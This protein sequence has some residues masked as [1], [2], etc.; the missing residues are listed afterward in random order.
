MQLIGEYL[1]KLKEIR[2]K[3]LDRMGEIMIGGLEGQQKDRDE[4]LEKAKEKELADNERALRE[5]LMDVETYNEKEIKINDKYR[6]YEMENEVKDNLDK[7]YL[8]QIL[9]IKKKEMMRRYLLAKKLMALAEIGLNTTVAIMS[10]L[11][12]PPPEGEVFALL[13]AQAGITQLIAAALTPIPALAKGTKKSKAGLHKVGEKGEELVMLPQH[14]KVLP[15][16]KTKLHSEVIDAMFDNRLEEYILKR[17][18]MPAVK[19]SRGN[20][21]DDYRLWKAVK[22]NK[23][24]SIDNISEVHQGFKRALEERDYVNSRRW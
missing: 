12:V 19:D 1:D 11:T 13:R 8:E 18:T 16:E 6:R 14:S 22:N 21:F 24:V 5:G 4:L 15:A 7:A 17:Y 9:L 23:N 20:G 10:A 3:E 2:E